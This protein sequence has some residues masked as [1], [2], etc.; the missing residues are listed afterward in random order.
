MMEHLPFWPGYKRIHN[1][2]GYHLR[3]WWSLFSEHCIRTRIIFHNVTSE[4]DPSFVLLILR[5]QLRIL[6]MTNIHQWRKMNFS[7]LIPCLFDHFFLVSDFGQ[8]PCRNF[9]QF[10]PF[11][12]R[13]C[14][15]IRK[16]HC[17]RLRNE[18]V[19]NTVVSHRNH[20][21][22]SD[23]ILMRCVYRSFYPWSRALVGINNTSIFCLAFPN[24][25]V[26]FSTALYR[27]FARHCCWH[28]NFQLSP[29]GF[30]C[31]CEFFIVWFYEVYSSHLS[32]IVEFWFLDSPSLFCFLFCCIRHMSPHIW[33][34]IV[35]TRG[36]F[37]L[38]V[39]PRTMCTHQ[40][41]FRSI[42]WILWSLS[43][44]QTILFLHPRSS[45]LQHVSPSSHLRCICSSG[46]VDVLRRNRKCFFFRHVQFDSWYNVRTINEFSSDRPEII[47]RFRIITGWVILKCGW[48]M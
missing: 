35:R 18:L 30:D 46:N 36:C 44:H 33:P 12:L 14:F 3:C 21:F 4:Y 40:V 15:C 48:S 11:F 45:N 1:F 19:N 6:K 27:Y 42:R 37:F 13:C 29:S 31:D 25:A 26:G 38:Y 17:S 41:A 32:G 22:C 43:M 39:S 20:P 23:V 2:R 24:T 9:L 16:F 7:A 28:R 10:F 5:F 8:L 47:F 34:Y